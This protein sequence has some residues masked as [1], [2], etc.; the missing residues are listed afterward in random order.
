MRILILAHYYP[1]EMG[2]AAAR[3]HGLARWMAHD[4]HD[5]TVVTAFPN[6]P[7]KR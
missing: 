6:Y 1:P 3:L 2:G 7:Y 5:V 4:G